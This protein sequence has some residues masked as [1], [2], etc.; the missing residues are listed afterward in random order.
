MISAIIKVTRQHKNKIKL[1]QQTLYTSGTFLKKT[2]SN[3]VKT[4]SKNPNSKK[5]FLYYKNIGPVLI[6]TRQRIEKK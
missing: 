3:N 4:A 6:E 2:H 5:V 1:Q